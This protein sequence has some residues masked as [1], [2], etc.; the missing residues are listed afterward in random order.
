M[1]LVEQDWRSF[2]DAVWGSIDTK[3]PLGIIPLL[4]SLVNDVWIQFCT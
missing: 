2:E 3:R 1:Y 4:A